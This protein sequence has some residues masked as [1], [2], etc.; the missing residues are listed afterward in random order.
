[1]RD[2]FAGRAPLARLLLGAP[3]AVALLAGCAPDREG[4]YDAVGHRTRDEL[5]AATNPPPPPPVAGLVGGGGADLASVSLPQGVTAEMVAA[6][7]SSFGLCAACHG[8]GG[9][10]SAVGPALNDGEWIHI[11]GEYDEIVGIITS[12]VAQ[13]R[14]YPA[15]MP[16]MGGGSF[17]EEQVREIAAY[18]YAISHQEGA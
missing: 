9:R 18:V 7:E 11:S 13:P 6:G 4:G 5:P 15:P 17:T 14:Q 16:A 3:L 2:V 8:P 12:G 10:G 1:M